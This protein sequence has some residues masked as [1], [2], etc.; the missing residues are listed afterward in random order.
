M[1]FDYLTEC[2]LHDW[3]DLLFQTLTPFSEVWYKILLVLVYCAVFGHHF[4]ILFSSWSSLCCYKGLLFVPVD[5][6]TGPKVTYSMCNNNHYEWKILN[7]MLFFVFFSTFI[8]PLKIQL[9]YCPTRA[10][11]QY[12]LPLANVRAVTSSQKSTQEPL[13]RSKPALTKSFRLTV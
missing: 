8:L 12:F 10:P 5:V 4:G 11:P 3:W 7:T 13:T 6:S 1:L 9:R 2:V